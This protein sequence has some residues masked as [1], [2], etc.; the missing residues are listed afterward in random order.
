MSTR[1][2]HP[3][4]SRPDAAAR[5]RAPGLLWPGSPRS[6]RRAAS[7][8]VAG[9]LLTLIGGLLLRG[10]TAEFGTVLALNALRVPGAD[11]LAEAVGTGLGPA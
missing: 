3:V 11:G 6:L 10:S 9:I 8:A 5:G 2:E 7:V 1:T 4:R